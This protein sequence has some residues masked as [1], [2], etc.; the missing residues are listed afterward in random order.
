MEA[1]IDYMS[2]DGNIH[3]EPILL[4]QAFFTVSQENH[5]H[6]KLEKCEFMHEEMEYLCL[7]VGYG[8]WKP[9]AS[10]MQLALVQFSTCNILYPSDTVHVMS[11]IVSVW[12]PVEIPCPVDVLFSA[13]C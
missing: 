13:I 5:L 6:I 2:L 11:C 1:Q 8:C 10:K 9:A 12:R 4:L 7:D 3:E